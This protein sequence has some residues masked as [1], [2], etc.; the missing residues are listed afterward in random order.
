[1]DRN[2]IGALAKGLVP[3][4]REAIAEALAPL[5]G[6]LTAI[7]ARPPEKGEAGPP[8]ECGP[9]GPPGPA[10]A[11]GI[12]GECGAKTMVPPDLAEQ[13][14][15]AVRLLHESPLLS[16]PATATRRIARIDRDENGSF[17][18]VYDETQT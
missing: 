14:A 8:G 7:E 16:Q 2:E 10:G 12:D 5:D 4:V 18:P 9:Q 15:S 11:N 13:V 3:F 6:R 1:M 17:V